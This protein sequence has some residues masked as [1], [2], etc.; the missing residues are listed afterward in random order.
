ML[1]SM[2]NKG[3]IRIP[4]GITVWQHELATAEVL[5][6][7][8]YVIEFLQVNPRKDTKS[9]DIVMNGEV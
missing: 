8:G 6:L 1:K 3:E 4:A 5:A 7:A 2:K 9:P